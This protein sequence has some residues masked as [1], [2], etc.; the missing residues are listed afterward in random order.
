MPLVAG[1]VT[2]S[3]AAYI[4]YAFWLR[5][6]SRSWRGHSLR[7][8]GGLAKWLPLFVWVPYAVVWLRPG[9]EIEIASWLALLGLVLVVA[10]IAFA[11][12]AAATLG[13]HFDVEVQVHRG[14]EVV[15]SGPYGLVRHPI[16]TGLGL[17]YLG[18]C[19]ATGNLLLLAGTLAVTFP[20]LYLRARAE[21][22]LLRSELGDAYDRYAREV[23]MLVPLPRPDAR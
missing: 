15:R 18:A 12:W 13:R 19:L 6:R 10:G 20:G 3:F 23:P 2:V 7:E 21:E 4:S 16:Y 5:A 22:E 17:H 11:I 9:P 14:H 1:V 8:R